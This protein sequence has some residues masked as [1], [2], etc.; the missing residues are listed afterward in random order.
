MRS[1]MV[2]SFA[3]LMP[4]SYPPAPMLSCCQVKL[5]VSEEPPLDAVVNVSFVEVEVWLPSLVDT[6]S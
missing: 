4:V 2:S 5:D 1:T 3:M 6:T